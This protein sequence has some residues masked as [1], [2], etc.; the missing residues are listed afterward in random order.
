MIEVLVLYTSRHGATA[1][2]ARALAAGVESVPGV[3]ARIRTVPAVSAN[4]EKTESD[5]PSDGP[6][7]ADLNDLRECAGLAL[8]SPTRFGNMAASMKYFIDNTVGAWLAGDLIDKPFCVFTSTGSLH[9]GQ[10]TTLH[11]MA[12][13]LIHHGMVWVG[14]PYSNAD[15]N[16][17]QTGG[18]PYGATH[19][20][21]P[22]GNL[23]LS[24]E[25]L[26][27][28]KAQ[29]KR[30]AQMAVALAPLREVNHG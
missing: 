11:T 18:T 21:G 30:L 23:P 20:A 10:E 19:V 3:E 22:Q 13:P 26:R 2:M 14:L 25:E 9:G 6:P 24:E 29:G 8:G 15:L 7:Y 16:T 1:Q 4:T 12:L 17:T 28:C 5:I 27:L